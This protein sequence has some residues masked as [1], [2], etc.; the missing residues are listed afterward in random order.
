MLLPSRPPSIVRP[1]SLVLLAPATAEVPQT[2]RRVDVDPLGHATV[3][4]NLQRLRGETYLRDGAITPDHL[5]TDGCHVQAA[6]GES[7]HVASLREDGSVAACARLRT[8]R[9]DC[10]PGALGIWSSALARSA[11]WSDRLWSA[12]EADL[13][14]ARQRGVHYVEF[15]GWA[16]GDE[17]RRTTMAVTTAMATYALGECVGGFL[18]VTTATVRHCSSRMMRKLGGHSFTAEG[19]TVPSYF[20]P[21]YGCEMELLRFDSKLPAQ[22][23]GPMVEHV[24]G[25]L[26]DVPVLCASRAI[27]ALSVVSH[28]SHAARLHQTASERVGSCLTA[29]ELAV[30]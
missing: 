22:R 17:W 13:T 6:D 7:W 26:L 12:I 15:G 25:S 30:A 5:T 21:Q 14:L 28:R 1:G 24:V 18:G 29:R 27:D 20:D 2:F 9:A 23:Y 11:A 4:A 16:V 19:V 10:A 3:L 8:H